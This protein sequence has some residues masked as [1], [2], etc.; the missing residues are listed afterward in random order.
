MFFHEFGEEWRGLD[1]AG[2]QLLGEIAV[3][4]S[5]LFAATMGLELMAVQDT[6]TAPAEIWLESGGALMTLAGAAA[7]YTFHRFPPKRKKLPMA[8]TVIDLAPHISSA[9]DTV[10]NSR[11]A[12]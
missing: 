5:G 3:F 11:Q 1:K 10:E 7:L 8:A 9:S 4:G 6:V 2:R 12:A